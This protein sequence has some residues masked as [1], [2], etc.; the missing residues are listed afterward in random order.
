M[1]RAEPEGTRA[2]LIDGAGSFPGSSADVL[3]GCGWCTDVW[4]CLGHQGWEGHGRHEA[5]GVGGD[6]SMK[7]FLNP[8]G[9]AS[10]A[11]RFAF[12][13]I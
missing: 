12:C 6:Q 7:G 9:L 10:P 11:A 1:L 2:V 4:L 3:R 5:R 13:S 8:A